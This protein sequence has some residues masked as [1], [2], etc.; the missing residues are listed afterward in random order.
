MAFVMDN[1]ST[2]AW[3]L[4]EPTLVDHASFG[5]RLRSEGVFVPGHWKLEVGN[6]LLQ[7]VRRKRIDEPDV[8]AFLTALG[9]LPIAIDEQFLEHAW[10]ATIS[11]AQRHTLTTYDAAYLELAV[12]LSLPLATLDGPLAKAA[13]AEGVEVIGG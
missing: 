13:I 9:A 6:A 4:S 7:G 2:M 3:L 10:N 1:S 11:L 5:N 12:R 8:M